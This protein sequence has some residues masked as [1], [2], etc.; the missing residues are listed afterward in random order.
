MNYNVPLRMKSRGGC[1]GGSGRVWRTLAEGFDRFSDPERNVLVRSHLVAQAEGNLM[2][3]PVN[4]P[5]PVRTVQQRPL[6]PERIRPFARTS[7]YAARGVWARVLARAWWLSPSHDPTPIFI[8]GCGRSGTTLLG[9]LFAKH[10]QIFYR[11]EPYHLW[12]AIQPA[13]DFVQIYSRGEHH[14]L[15]DG[16][17]VTPTAQGRFQR[18][19]SPSPGLTLVEKSPINTLRLGYLDAMAPRARFVHI[20]RDGI[21]VTR[22]I[23]Q[24]AAVTRRMAFRPPLNEWWGVGDAKWTALQRDGIAAGYYPDEV[25]QLTTDA[26]RGAYEWLLSLREVDAWR[27]RLGPR[28]IELRYV[29]LTDDPGTTL[30]AVTDSLGLS[31]PEQWLRQVAALVRPA[32]SSLKEPLPLPRQMCADFNSFQARFEFAGRAIVKELAADTRVARQADSFPV[33]VTSSRS[34]AVPVGAPVSPHEPAPAVASA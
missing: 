12:A 25:S 21:D 30:K 34:L 31:C 5:G 8:I 3:D 17:S 6:V 14:C 19:M 13:T 16:N 9:E 23:R 7:Y 28:L 20:V 33:G 22:S 26:Q 24:I 2:T 32:A 1:H 29:D 4:S 18:L 10:P 27:E 11:Y 15:L